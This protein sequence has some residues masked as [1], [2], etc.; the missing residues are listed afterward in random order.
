MRN[1]KDKHIANT[2]SMAEKYKLELSEEVGPH[3]FSPNRIALLKVSRCWELALVIVGDDS[4]THTHT[5][6]PNAHTNKR[7]SYI[8]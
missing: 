8:H 7:P 6:T 1:S 2:K 5:H 4:F 3:A